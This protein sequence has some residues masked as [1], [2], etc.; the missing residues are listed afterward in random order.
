MTTLVLGAIA[1]SDL[2]NVTTTFR[3]GGTYFLDGA[4]MV[5]GL[6]NFFIGAI[7]DVAG[8]HL[9]PNQPTNQTQFIILMPEVELDYGDA[10]DQYPTMFDDNGARH[11]ITENPLYLGVDLG[12]D[13]DGQP[14]AGA[15]L[16]DDDG[17]DIGS[18]FNRYLTTPV[19]VTSSGRGI[20]DAWVDFNQ[21]GDWKDPGEQVL[22]GQ[23]LLPGENDFGL[24][25]PALAKAGYT[26][27]RFR[28]SSTG[29]LLPGGVATDGEVEDYVVEVVPGQPPTALDDSGYATTENADLD[30]PLP[31]VLDNDTDPDGDPVTVMWADAVSAWGASVVMDLATGLFTYDPTNAPLLQGL[32]DGEVI[33]DTFQYQATDGKL[34]S[35]TI[36][37]VNIDVT[38]VNDM[39]EAVDDL[40]DTDEDTPI[41]IAAPGVLDNDT[42]ADADD[43]LTVT[44]SDSSSDLGA[45]VV[46]YADGS[47]QYDPTTSPT[48]QGL[49]ENEQETDRFSYT[50]E[51]ESGAESTAIVEIVV[52]GVN[53][54]PTA[55]D[56]TYAIDEDT[57]LLIGPDGVLGNDFD[58]DGDPIQVV[59]ADTLSALGS[60]RHGE[61]R[62]F[63]H[64]RPD[65]CRQVAG[66]GPG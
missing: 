42:D 10:P 14:S 65:R 17:V 55:A 58:I 45:T 64:L 60:R 57:P 1:D 34:P 46:V 52:D 16:D 49:Q 56:D 27:A 33:T 47:F 22:V 48:L 2:T 29:G 40:Y 59:D 6:P 8:N 32:R 54:D 37:T 35:L 25:T 62:W 38:G 24:S 50:I 44:A 39:P 15:D 30:E 11:A 9:Q 19:T 63:L 5:S 12:G 36:A 3:G 66:I 13:A 61:R 51:D 21:D 23:V 31:S 20:M 4:R 53:D 41:D 28:V 7:K 18:V 43:V 26:Y